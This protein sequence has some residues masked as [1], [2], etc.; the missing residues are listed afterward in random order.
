M[1]QKTAVTRLTPRGRGAVAVTRLVG[2]NAGK[3]L[4]ELFRRAD[5]RTL[6]PKDF[7]RY[8]DRPIFGRLELF[9]GGA[10]QA[11]RE[12]TIV[13]L[14]SPE[15]IEIHS[16]GGD[17][18]VSAIVRAATALGAVETNPFDE[19]QESFTAAAER[20][21]SEARTEM[22][23]QFLLD[24]YHGAAENYLRK[25]LRD[26]AAFGL[27]TSEQQRN[28]HLARLDRILSFASFGTHLTC[29]FLVVFA[30]PVNVGK[31]S[32]FNAL[33]G[34]ERA[35]ADRQPGTTRDAVLAETAFDGRLVRLADTAGWRPTQNQTEREGIALAVSLIQK[36]DLILTV[37]DLTAEPIALDA[38]LAAALESRAGQTMAIFNK[39]DRPQKDWNRA[40]FHSALRSG[41]PVVSAFDESSLR[42]IP[43]RI[44]T[45]LVPCL[46]ESGEPIP[47]TEA[48][49]LLFGRLRSL[50]AEKKDDQ[51]REQLAALCDSRR[52]QSADRS[53]CGP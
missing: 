19:S 53:T 50:L 3:I 43:S 25:L 37:F 8:S 41:A 36:A 2:P 12:E 51:L 7:T 27:K 46:P 9:V 1:R 32:L 10:P 48:Q 17:A 11:V 5:G 14:I 34:Y 33:L 30:G 42:P 4:T 35:I 40:T 26:S 31:S 52:T 18:V 38:Q 20:L 28:E 45:R 16:H 24:Q 47:L 21:L 29:P 23:V 22:A 44:A 49:T 6:A 13:R 15:E 39:S